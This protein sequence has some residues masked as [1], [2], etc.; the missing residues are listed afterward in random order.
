MA[1]KRMWLISLALLVGASS[2]SDWVLDTLAPSTDSSYASGH[3][4]L[5]IRL[6][7]LLL[8]VCAVAAGAALVLDFRASATVSFHRRTFAFLPAL[9]FAAQEHIDYVAGGGRHPWTLMLHWSFLF[10][11]LIQLPLMLALYLLA[12]MLIRAVKRVLARRRTALRAGSVVVA[13]PLSDLLLPRR[14]RPPRDAR[15][16]R[17]PPLPSF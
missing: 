14:A 15:V 2:A 9:V 10:G 6:I 7:P 1:G 4:G 5:G 12:R 16:D 8:A 11:V 17:G 3:T 13:S